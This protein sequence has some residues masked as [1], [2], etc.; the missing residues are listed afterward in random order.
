MS[1][2]QSLDRSASSSVAAPRATLPLVVAGLGVAWNAYGVVQFVQ[3]LRDT[4]ADLMKMGMTGEQAAVYT[5]Y[6]AWMTAAFAVG[7]GGGLAGSLLLLMRR[8]AAVPVFVASL[9]GYVV[10]FLGD[11]TEGVFA[12]L[13]AK[14]VTILSVVVV[15]AA[16]LLGWSWRLR[17]GDVERGRARAT[18]IEPQ[19]VSGTE[20]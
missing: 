12:A 7:V 13:G 15:I 18:E 17:S 11:I 3:T 2:E 1:L 5:S 6:P 4:P 10:L 8:K 9:V 14:Q 19:S 16:A 20:R